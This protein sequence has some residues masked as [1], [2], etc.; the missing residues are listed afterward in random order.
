MKKWFQ[1]NWDKIITV[2]VSIIISG[3]VG[4]FSGI[5]AIKSDIS[6]LS[7]RVT[8]NETEITSSIKPSI[9]TFTKK[10]DKILYIEK[11]LDALKRQ[12]AIAQ[13]VNHL[14]NLTIEQQRAKT[15]NELKELIAEVKIDLAVKKQ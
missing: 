1:E 3:A 9:T 4:F 6:K 12:T 11:E 13:Q 7:E 15:I 10:S 2:I 8:R 14:L 5:L